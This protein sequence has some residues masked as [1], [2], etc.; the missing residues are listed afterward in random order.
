[1][2]AAAKPSTAPQDASRPKTVTTKTVTT[3]TVTTKTKHVSTSRNVSNTKTKAKK[4]KGKKN[5]MAVALEANQE[6]KRQRAIAVRSLFNTP[7]PN[8][9]RISLM[10]EWMMLKMFAFAFIAIRQLRVVIWFRLATNT[11]PPVEIGEI[12]GMVAACAKGGYTLLPL[13]LLSWC[14]Q[15]YQIY[16]TLTSIGEPYRS[17][18]FHAI[19]GQ[20]PIALVDMSI[21][22]VTWY[23]FTRTCYPMY[24]PFI[25]ALC[26]APM[27]FLWPLGFVAW[28]S[29]Y[30]FLS[31]LLRNPCIRLDHL[32]VNRTER[33]EIKKKIVKL[34]KELDAKDMAQEALDAIGT[35]PAPEVVTVPP[36]GM[37]PRA[38]EA[39]QKRRRDMRELLEKMLNGESIDVKEPPKKADKDKKDKK[40]K[41]DEKTEREKKKEPEKKKTDSGEVVINEIDVD[42]PPTT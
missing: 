39:K 9:Y 32:V 11:N 30:D 6:Q 37:T 33:I 24:F 20:I 27:V 16:Y 31:K 35:I 10:N 18:T 40:D 29:Y 25:L 17:P 21:L 2:A 42:G 26:E 38:W 14:T 23:Y 13:L 28:Y 34:A 12:D 36:E 5:R 3:K 7:A 41:K 4:K 8:N 15:N 22:G 1:M 19:L